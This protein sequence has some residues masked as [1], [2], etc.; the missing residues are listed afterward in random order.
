M[1]EISLAA[2]VPMRIPAV[3]VET[4]ATGF[5]ASH[6]SKELEPGRA[7][8]YERDGAS[9]EARVIWTHVLEGRRMSGFLVVREPNN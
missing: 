1:V 5:R 3:L 7:V 2:P 4:S 6:D 8:H 9:G